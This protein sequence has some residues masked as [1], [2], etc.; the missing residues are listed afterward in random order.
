M[1][2]SYISAPN[3]M[4]GLD[5][6]LDACLSKSSTATSLSCMR[7]MVCPITVTELS[8]PY[9]SRCFSQC[10]HSGTPGGGRSAM[11]PRSGMP[12]GPGGSGSR[13]RLRLKMILL[14]MNKLRARMMLYATNDRAI[15]EDSGSRKYEANSSRLAN[16]NLKTEKPLCF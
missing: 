4:D 15:L 8:G 14:M 1:W 13:P 5:E 6:Y 2:R 3:T 10:C 16:R 7:I 9:N 12:F 11:F